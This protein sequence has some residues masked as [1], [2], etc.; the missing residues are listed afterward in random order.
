MG[1]DQ[2]KKKLVVV[3]IV[4]IKHLPANQ[5]QNRRR[6]REKQ[7]LL[8]HQ[9]QRAAPS[10][11][12]SSGSS[13]CRMKAI[14][15]SQCPTP[16]YC[17]PVPKCYWTM[18][19]AHLGGER[20]LRHAAYCSPAVCW[21]RSAGTADLGQRSDTFLLHCKSMAKPQAPRCTGHHKHPEVPE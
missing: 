15:V 1:R 13:R 4:K 6:D 2:K 11:N 20:M 16:W 3:E 14:T 18:R 21:A 10:G 5:R 9:W 8:L 17:P 19:A 12:Q 7:S